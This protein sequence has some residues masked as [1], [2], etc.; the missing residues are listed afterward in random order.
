MARIPDRIDDVAEF[1]AIEDAVLPVLRDAFPDVRVV[2]LISEDTPDPFPFILVRGSHETGLWEGDERFIDV[3]MVAIHVFTE[4]PDGDW[5]AARL[6]EAVRVALRNAARQQFRLP[7]GSRIHSVTMTSRPRRVTDW[8]TASGPVQ[9]ADLPSGTWR[10][11]TL[12][13]VSVRRSGS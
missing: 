13:R 12:F 7:D 11:E 8:A 6:S 4:D 1:L 3:A 10:Y 5:Q 2:S 9:Y